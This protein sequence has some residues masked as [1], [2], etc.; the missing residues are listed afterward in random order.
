[1]S[2]LDD[3][4]AQF[5]G[6][7]VNVDG[8]YGPQCMDL[9]HEWARWLGADFAPAAGAADEVG[10]DWAGWTWV[11]NTPEGVPPPG[12]LVVWDRRIGPYGHI[13]ISL[14]GDA[15]NFTQFAQNWIN[16][17]EQGSPAAV[18]PMT[19]YGGVAGWQVRD[20]WENGP[21]ATPA[22]APS[23]E[24][25]VAALEDWLVRFGS[26]NLVNLNEGLGEVA[27]HLRAIADL[28]EGRGFHPPS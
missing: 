10:A 4:V 20:G 26:P 16:S 25:R 13:G 21:P 9:A 3:F 28:L 6:A 1:M 15:L 7:S 22:P 17:S 24:A 14:G 11:A 18:V 27:A 2:L 5:N 23:L 8:V 19:G 12:A